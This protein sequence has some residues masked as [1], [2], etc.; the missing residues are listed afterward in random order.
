MLN[1]SQTEQLEGYYRSLLRQ[2]QSLPENTAT[3]AIYVLLGT[4]PIQARIHIRTLTLL[5]AIGR[6]PSKHPIRR[7]AI[8]QLA[9]PQSPHRS[10]FMH[11]PEIREEYGVDIRQQVLCPWPKPTW[12]AYIWTVVETWRQRLVQNVTRKSTLH[13]LRH[14]SKEGNTHSVV[15][16]QGRPL[17]GKQGHS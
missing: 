1:K 2:V 16:L 14:S 5:G 15:K 4:I 7:I 9:R 13:R 11:A 12:K 3:E 8:R 6:L 10:W 17:P